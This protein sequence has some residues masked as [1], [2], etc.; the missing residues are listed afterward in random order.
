MQDKIEMQGKDHVIKYKGKKTQKPRVFI[1]NHSNHNLSNAEEFGE[2]V[3]LTR[4][5]INVFNTERLLWT[6]REELVLR[7]R[8]DFET[9]YLAIVGSNIISFLA[10]VVLGVYPQVKLLLWDAVKRQYDLK[11]TNLRQEY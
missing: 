3:L 5:N 2:V 7:N 1:L 10:G 8:F 4:G 6:I 9:D 11:I